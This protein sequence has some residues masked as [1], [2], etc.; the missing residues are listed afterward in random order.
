M[1]FKLNSKLKNNAGN[2]NFIESFGRFSTQWNNAG[3][4]HPIDYQ[5]MTKA[6]HL[7]RMVAKE[8]PTMS[9]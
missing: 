3:Y 4:S 6:K 9:L 1:G 8:N 7:A 2:S 5:T